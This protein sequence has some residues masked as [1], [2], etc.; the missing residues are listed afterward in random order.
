MLYEIA[1]KTS[2]LSEIPNLEI[3]SLSF[4]ICEFNV[5][6]VFALSFSKS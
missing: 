6:Y 3:K 4:A 5:V 2:G 1:S